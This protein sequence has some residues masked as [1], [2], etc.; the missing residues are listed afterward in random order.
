MNNRTPDS[1][2]AWTKKWG[3]GHTCMGAG[4]KAPCLYP[5]NFSVF[6]RLLP[7]FEQA[8]AY[9][10]VNFHFTSGNNEN[11]T[12]AEIRM[13]ALICPTD[14]NVNSVSIIVP[15]LAGT[16]GA[17]GYLFNQ[18]GPLPPGSWMQAFSS[19]AGCTGTFD[20]GGYITNYDLTATAG[21]GN[22][23]SQFNGV[24][25]NDSATKIAEITD[26]TSNTIMFGEHC[27]T[28]LLVFDPAFG[29]SDNSWQSGR[30]YDTL[31]ATMYPPNIKVSPTTTG[32][33]VLG[34]GNYYYPTVA[35]SQHTGGANF[36]FCDG[37]VKFLKS[38]INSWATPNAIGPHSSSLPAGSA[39]STS[40]FIFAQGTA[41]PG[42]YQALSSRNG[43]EV[44]SSDAY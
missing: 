28:N 17:P 29:V 8:Q 18:L 20:S 31:F 33:S 1:H 25:Y 5:E 40:C 22:Q 41:Q 19:Y 6:V 26:G 10:A 7:Y 13:S 9:N 36:A 2:Y 11:I 14:S 16:A 43:S 21:C 3:A 15:G 34:T 24:I 12:I 23:R 39:Y 42:V 35:T 32:A 30:W 4:S 44:I 37:S 27:H 38:T